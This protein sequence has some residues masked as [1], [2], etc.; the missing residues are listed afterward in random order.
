MARADGA[1]A[2]PDDEIVIDL[3]DGRGRIALRRD[4]A[5]DGSAWAEIRVRVPLAD[6]E[7]AARRQLAGLL[8]RLRD[9]A[10]EVAE[11]RRP[12]P[13]RQTRKDHQ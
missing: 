5:G 3:L 12:A 1:G 8:I 6:G 11:K 4:L 9:L 7:V 13:R 10:A 2:M